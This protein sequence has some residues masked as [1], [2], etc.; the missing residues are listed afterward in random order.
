MTQRYSSAR[1]AAFRRQNG[2]CHYCKFL[3]WLTDRAS[4]AAAHGLTLRQA[5]R[6]QATAEHLVA[7]QDGGRNGTNIAAACYHCNQARHRFRPN[8]APDPD[9]FRARVQTRVKHGRWHMP[10][11]FHARTG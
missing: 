8:A 1:N 2:R 10:A 4:F 11:L 7:R 9:R 5:S 3:M 6:L